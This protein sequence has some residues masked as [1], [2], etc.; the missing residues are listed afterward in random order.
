MEL[1]FKASGRA[2]TRFLWSLRKIKDNSFKVSGL[3][4]SGL[5]V[6]GFKV[7]SPHNLI[8]RLRRSLKREPH[9]LI[10]YLP[11]SSFYY[12][13]TNGHRPNGKVKLSCFYIHSSFAR[14]TILIF[15]VICHHLHP[16][17][18]LSMP[19][20]GDRWVTDDFCCHQ[21]RHQKCNTPSWRRLHQKSL[22]LCGL[23]PVSKSSVTTSKK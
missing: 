13:R 7:K 12:F 22:F 10:T 8:A 3:Q 20:H 19:Y 21:H 11:L 2:E 1:S 23:S 4:V 16:N 18:L 14:M 17:Y 9:N 6:S 15:T 5:Q